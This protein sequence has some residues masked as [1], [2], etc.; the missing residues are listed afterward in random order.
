L[1][2]VDAETLHAAIT[3]WTDCGYAIT[4]GRTGD[5]GAIGVHLLAGGEKRSK[6][7]STAAECEDFLTSV[8][9]PVGEQST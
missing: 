5:G 7:F 8:P 2:E 1:A 3:R 9:G 6:Y 4:F